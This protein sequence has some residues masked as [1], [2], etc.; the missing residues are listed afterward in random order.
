MP[1]VT[2]RT[3]PSCSVVVPP[4][5]T[6][7][8]PACG[9][10]MDAAAPPPA[11]AAHAPRAPAPAESFARTLPGLDQSSIVLPVVLA[12]A[13]AGAGALLWAFL[14]WIASVEIGYVAWGVGA[15]AGG[16]AVL[17]GGRGNA[18]AVAAAAA[19]FVGIAAGKLYGTHLLV[20]HQLAA[21]E[22]MFDR[23][24]FERMRDYANRAEDVPAA[25]GEEVEIDFAAFADEDDGEDAG[26]DAEPMTPEQMAEIEAAC[27]AA[28]AAHAAELAMLRD[29]AVTFEQWRA[30]QRATMRAHVRV[31]DLVR[32]SLGPIDVLFVLLGVCTAFGLVRRASPSGPLGA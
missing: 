13:G 18:I 27:A 15:L 12:V 3:C 24:A 1:N 10:A 32:E 7:Y 29:P 31:F 22:A 14:A 9:A 20:E 11:H 19:A 5:T 25:P 17:G 21:V 2:P 26:E 4:R 6:K 23:T 28:A 16:G 30:H 8:C